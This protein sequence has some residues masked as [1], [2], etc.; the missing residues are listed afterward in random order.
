MAAWL[1]AVISSAKSFAR[2]RRGGIA[3]YA[4]IA[5]PAL[6]V[7]GGGVLDITAV[8]SDQSRLRSVAEGAALVGA[9]DLGMATHADMALDRAVAWAEA[10]MEGWVDT[11]DTTVT[12][13]IVELDRGR[14]GIEVTIVGNRA[15]LFGRLLPPGGWTIRVDAVAAPVN[16]TPLC[17]LATLNRDS[18]VLNI[19]DEG[20]LRAPDCLVHSNRDI[21]VENNGE[22]DADM[23]SAVMGVD[24]ADG[25]SDAPTIA[26]PFADLNLRPPS[27][28]FSTTREYTTGTH[29]LPAG[30]HCATIKVQ[31]DA[32]LHLEPGEH[33][34]VNA[35]FEAKENARVEGDDVVL[36]FD[37]KSKFK[38]DDLARVTLNGREDGPL[39]GFVLAT[40]RGNDKDFI[41]TSENVESLLGVI[42]IP[43]ARL[44]V[45]GKADVARESAW[46]VIVARSIQLK[47]NPTVFV[48]ANYRSAPVPVPEGVGPNSSGP[49]LVR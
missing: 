15:S 45:D 30:V 47:G 1:A 31:G 29:S 32:V 44:I 28:T 34:F 16:T 25:V 13:R 5:L 39:S 37:K 22:I 27:C 6:L 43:D 36:V 46:T 40:Q 9:G 8:Y 3:V 12:S 49:V 18:K 19:K 17:V 41:I 10:E 33:W 42:Y 7:L 24:G 38:F 14:R 48:N 26:D 23:L 11:F 21:V 2:A 35:D 20:L 4:S